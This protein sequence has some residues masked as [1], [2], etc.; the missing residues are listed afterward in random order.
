MVEES[1]LKQWRDA[2][3]VARRTLEGIKGEI[4]EGKTWDQVIDSAE[5]FIRRH[6]GTPAF[7]VTISVNDIAAHYT[8]NSQ[9]TAPNGFEGEM[10]FQKG[11]LVKLDVG[12]HIAG[13]LADNALTVEVGNGG[14]HTDQ[15]KAAKDARDAAIE[16]M[17]PG[18]PWHKIGAAAEQA[19][20]DAGFEPIRNL[21][22]HELKRWN[23]H[24]G[25]SIPSH[26]C[27][28]E[29]PGF[30][31]GVEVG[32]VY[33]VEPFN[34]TGKSGMVEDIPPFSS[35]N[36]FRVTGDITIRK[37]MSKGKLKPLGATMAR[38]IEE[39]YHTLPFAE[40]WSYPL[41]EKPFPGED[42]ETLR[43]KWNA[44]I[45]KLISIR[46]LETYTALRCVDAGKKTTVGQFEHTVWITE[47]GP[48]ILTVE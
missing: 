7:P 27:G 29:N 18:T 19:H 36:I 6:G 41:L 31:G 10:I 45:K 23:L 44:L 2:G 21:C 37:A 13:A 25:T 30:K 14:N 20:T 34:T 38:Y 32:S 40:R 43:K 17:H 3:H 15:I 26:N 11:D 22:G 42:E 9:L 16:K 4:V 46:F 28:S 47:G 1:D 33:A 8:T 48:E 24:A 39:R 35:S 5:R 12:V